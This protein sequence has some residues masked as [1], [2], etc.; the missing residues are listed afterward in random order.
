[1]QSLPQ[2]DR[3]IDFSSR[4]EMLFNFDQANQQLNISI[5]QAWLAWHSEN[6]AP[7]STWK[8]GV[9]GVLM[10]YNLFASSYR[11]QDGSSSTNLNA[12]GTAGINAGAWR[13]RSDYQLNK[14]DSEDNH[15]QSGGI[16]RTYLFRPLPQLGSK[17]TLGETDFSS[18]IF[19]GFSYTGAALASDDRML[20]WELRGYA[21]QI[22]GIAQTNATVTISQSGRVI[23]QKKVPPGPFIIDDLNQSVQGTLDVKVTEEDGRVNNF[24]VSAASTPLLTRQGQV[25][26]KLAAGQPRPSMSHQTENETFFSNEVSWGMLSNTS[27]YGGLLISDDDYHSA[28]MGIGQNML[29]LGALSFDVT[30]ASSHFDTQQDERGLSYRFNYSKQVDAT[31]STISLAAYR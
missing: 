22:S 11:P 17:L 27:L 26:Y 10:D 6:W 30:W 2:I 4:P 12:Y 7:P 18:N 5:P 23:Y 19:D 8:E 14:T 1:R 20:P 24:Q 16:S 13:L 31:N 29:W 15:D 28:A 25:R 3:C 21:P 9:A